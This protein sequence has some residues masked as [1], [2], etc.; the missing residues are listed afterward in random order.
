[1]NFIRFVFALWVVPVVAWSDVTIPKLELNGKTYKSATLTKTSPLK[2]KIRHSAGI[3]FV[4]LADLPPDLQRELGYD[5]SEAENAAVLLA[6]PRFLATRAEN[7]GE[8]VM[9]LYEFAGRFDPDA[10]KAFCLERKQASPAKAFYFVVIFDSAANAKFPASPFTAEYGIE[11]DVIRHIRAI[12]CFN[13]VNG[14]SNVRYH[15]ANIW[16]YSAATMKP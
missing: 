5:P 15:N 4:P 10:L 3:A 1:M 13:R 8:N 7:G 2:A 11:E 6:T 12:Y 9:D 16:D 14:Y